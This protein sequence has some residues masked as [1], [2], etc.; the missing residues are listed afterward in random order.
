MPQT[1]LRKLFFN[2]W[3]ALLHDLFWIP[4]ALFCAYWI[5]FNFESIPSRY[6]PVFYQILLVIFPLQGLFLW[7]FGLYR[8]MWRFASLP[9]LLRILKAVFSGT[10]VLLLVFFQF[11]RLDGLPRTVIFLYPLLLVCG[12]A[13]P[14]FCYRL[15]KDRHKIFSKQEGK[16]TLIVGAGQG[17]E[18]LVRDLLRRPEY[19]PVCL[20]DDN[21]AKHGREIHGVRVYGSLDDIED[22]VGSYDIELVLLAIPSAGRKVVQRVASVCAKIGVTCHTLPSLQDMNGHQETTSQLRSLTLEDLLGRDSVKLDHQAILGYLGGKTVLVTGGGGSI[23]SEL[24]RQVAGLHPSR[25]IIFDHSEFNLYAIDIELHASFPDLKIISVLG[26]MK[27]YDRVDWVFRKFSPDVVFH[28]AAYKHVPMLELNPAEGVRNNVFGTKMVADAADRYHV[29]R[30]VLVSTDKA[31]NPANV[32]GTTKRIAEIYCQNLNLR[33]QT[34][35]VTTRFGNVLGSAGSVVPLFEKQIAQGGPVTV[36][37]REIKRYFMTIPEAVS[38]ILQAGSMGKGGEIFVLEMGEP[39]FIKDLAE[40]MIRLSGLEPD[41]DIKIEY[42]GLRPGEKL[43][44]EIF[45]ESEDLRGTSHP[46]LQLARARQCDWQWLATVL[47]ELSRAATSRN[48]P[49]LI[50]HLR[51]IVPEYN[52]LHVSDNE[53]KATGSVPLRLH[54]AARDCRPTG[55]MG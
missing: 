6:F 49:E 47:D 40:Q 36:T 53:K 11:N 37:H 38:L 18:L 14:R 44:E 43:F 32:M 24:C 16:R 27:N 25:L 15:I 12:L 26:D 23:G 4:L 46:K 30:F 9:D 55:L 19:M 29:D 8:G 17:G 1:Y 48:V 31:V 22:L 10:A 42:I 39:V 34:K 41:R 21:H 33:S 45:H 13:G 20:V 3:A 28:A 7:I 2:R 5:R 54:K 35:F 50:R 51:E 52:G